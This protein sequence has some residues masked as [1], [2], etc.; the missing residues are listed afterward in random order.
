M[1]YVFGIFTYKEFNRLKITKNI[2]VLFSKN[3]FTPKL[4]S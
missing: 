3:M 1:I 2:L 4:L